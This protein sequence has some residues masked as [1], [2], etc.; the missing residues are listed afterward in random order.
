MNTSELEEILKKIDSTKKIFGGVYASD[1]LPLE[2]KQYPQ[3]FVVDVDTS[4]KPGAH[5]V[6]LYFIDD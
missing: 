5:L 4:E 3:S 1:L 6:A 2:V